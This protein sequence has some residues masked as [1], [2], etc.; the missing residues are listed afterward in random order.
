MKF[1]YV[2]VLDFK[3]QVEPSCTFHCSICN[4]YGAMDLQLI[5]LTNL[6]MSDMC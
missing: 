4:W 5:F 3:K 6:E 1:S 2:D